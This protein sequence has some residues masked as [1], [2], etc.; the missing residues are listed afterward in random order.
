MM[1]RLGLES[2]RRKLTQDS[3]QIVTNLK[4]MKR[5]PAT[6]ED[7][8]RRA[9]SAGRREA[10]PLQ[11]QPLT[12]S[13]ILQRGMQQVLS[14][15]RTHRVEVSKELKE[16]IS[17]AF[18]AMGL[19]LKDASVGQSRGNGAMGNEFQKTLRD[20]EGEFSQA[21]QALGISVKLATIQLDKLELDMNSFKSSISR[22]GDKRDS[23]FTTYSAGFSERSTSQNSKER[24][25]SAAGYRLA[26]VQKGLVQLGAEIKKMGVK[27]KTFDE[28]FAK[29]DAAAQAILSAYK[30]AS[31]DQAE[32][33][34][35]QK[36]D[37][38][39]R[40]RVSVEESESRHTRTRYAVRPVDDSAAG[41]Q[42]EK[43]CNEAETYLNTMERL[44]RVVI[45]RD[46]GSI[47][48]TK[49][50]LETHKKALTSL[51]ASSRAAGS[52]SSRYK[53]ASTNRE[54][55]SSRDQ[56]L[57]AVQRKYKQMET[58]YER[59]SDELI[60]YQDNLLGHIE[61]LKRK[62]L[63]IE[64][65]QRE[66]VSYRE[67]LQSLQEE[68]GRDPADVGLGQSR[69]QVLETVRDV[70]RGM[71]DAYQG[72]EDNCSGRLDMI[73]E[74]VRSMH[75]KLRRC[76]KSVRIGARAKD[77]ERILREN[78][79]LKEEG[80]RLEAENRRITRENAAL[81]KS[82]EEHEQMRNEIDGLRKENSGLKNGLE[83]QSA[84]AR[85]Y[86]AQMASIMNETFETRQKEIDSLLGEKLERMDT[87]KANFE[88]IMELLGTQVNEQV[89]TI[90]QLREEN[91]ALK[92]E[93]SG[94]AVE[95]FAARRPTAK[96][97]DETAR[98]EQLFAQC[99]EAQE[100]LG[101]KAELL[102]SAAAD[103]TKR[104]EEILEGYEQLKEKM[105]G[106]LQ[107]L[108]QAAEKGKQTENRARDLRTRLAQKDADMVELQQ[109]LRTSEERL[110][111]AEEKS[112]SRI[113]TLEKE[114]GTAKSQCEV[115][116]AENEELTEVNRILRDENA[117]LDGR[118]KALKEQR[119]ASTID[120]IV[121]I[122][123]G[124]RTNYAELREHC[125]AALS[126]FALQIKDQLPPEL[127]SAISRRDSAF[128][129][130]AAIVISGM[131]SLMSFVRSAH[132]SYSQTQSESVAQISLQVSSACGLVAETQ[133]KQ[134]D[135]C[136]SARQIQSKLAVLP[137]ALEDLKS[138]CAETIRAGKASCLRKVR[139]LFE[140][141]KARSI[142]PGAEQQAGEK[143]RLIKALNRQIAA[144][145]DRSEKSMEEVDLKCEEL[146]RRLA[147][148]VAAL[149]EAQ[150]GLA[151]EF[152]GKQAELELVR[153]DY[154]PKL[155]KEREKCA[156]LEMENGS[157]NLRVKELTQRIEAYNTQITT[158]SDELKAKVVALEDSNQR[159]LEE[160]CTLSEA[161]TQ[162]AAKLADL[163]SALGEE[164]DKSTRDAKVLEDHES[165]LR[166]EL[167][168]AIASKQALQGE[169]RCAVEKIQQLDTRLGELTAN[170]KAL[171]AAKQREDDL[172]AKLAEVVAEN[173]NLRAN[174]SA[175]E[176]AR[177]ELAATLVQAKKQHTEF[178]E[179]TLR[180]K[181]GLEV[182]AAEKSALD[183]KCSE[184]REENKRQSAKMQELAADRETREKNEEGL[185][186]LLAAAEIAGPQMGD[187]YE[188]KIADLSNENADLKKQLDEREAAMKESEELYSAQLAEE[189]KKSDDL[190]QQVLATETKCERLEDEGKRR[191]AD[192]G[193]LNLQLSQ[194]SQPAKDTSTADMKLQDA[195]DS[196][197]RLEGEAK[198]LQ[199]QLE[200]SQAKT[201]DAEEK[202]RELEEQKEALGKRVVAGEEQMKE[203]EQEN[204]ELRLQCQTAI[205]AQN[206]LAQ[207]RAV[208]GPA[209]DELLGDFAQVT[210][211]KFDELAGTIARV[212][213]K[214]KL[215]CDLRSG[216]REPTEEARQILS[217]AVGSSTEG[218]AQLAQKAVNMLSKKARERSEVREAIRG[219]VA[220]VNWKIA[221][222]TAK[223]DARFR[224]FEETLSGTIK[225]IVASVSQRLQ[226]AAAP[227]TNLELEELRTDAARARIV[228]LGLL[229]TH[230]LSATH[231]QSLS[232]L[233]AAARGLVETQ[234]SSIRSL[235]DNCADIDRERS[236]LVK[237]LSSHKRES[238]ACFEA[239][240]KCVD[241]LTPG[242]VMATAFQRLAQLGS[243][244]EHAESKMRAAWKKSGERSGAALEKLRHTLATANNGLDLFA[245]QTAEKSK[246]AQEQQERIKKLE[247][248][249][250]SNVRVI[251]R[252][253]EELSHTIEDYGITLNE[254]QRGDLDDLVRTTLSI[255][256][257]SNKRSGGGSDHHSGKGDELMLTD[258]DFKVARKSSR[259]LL[260]LQFQF[261]RRRSGRSGR[262]S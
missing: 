174:L 144:A 73:A 61:R 25:E 188:K 198:K 124:I 36:D 54:V 41:S 38:I 15:L 58:Q 257:M 245:T 248:L 237:A 53:S 153:A 148:T 97:G 176:K 78:T 29:K 50:E 252:A 111:Q 162:L 88:S 105:R 40:L 154:E 145:G 137:E 164:K 258:E 114:I 141:A 9:Q 48:R 250:E 190:F 56:E 158:D 2:I 255:M 167:E 166:N 211:D 94:S 228:L 139:D 136:H 243:R 196:R 66:L 43:V 185:K 125:E 209:L 180:L 14:A 143:D 191:E 205:R 150:K 109:K 126:E 81:K 172:K 261:R 232:E 106:T 35:A 117:E 22:K 212:Q 206:E 242:N 247:E 130:R 18:D 37:E 104:A 195:L 108:T 170:S 118:C 259:L 256:E 122:A 103:R 163:T 262:R 47:E 193:R 115:K 121:R 24:P 152:E 135:L 131:K 240:R 49:Q 207:E 234:D 183:S 233:S 123:S 100:T 83:A 187:G 210:D 59:Q 85:D 69:V 238:R 213:E 223:A 182:T 45:K 184:L 75:E 119:G 244:V 220:G 74:S 236:A 142:V 138:S 3:N 23:R 76:A 19:S 224:K 7:I 11:G 16:T 42:L 161:K 200:L 82:I 113:A 127:R 227:K 95:E 89:E 203:I 31:V 249:A 26:N 253:C 80:K 39:R 217:K 79:A 102:A 149:E 129:S 226:A 72:L 254:V 21:R 44:R 93:P 116:E 246:E 1:F 10:S 52:C 57:L 171:D 189:R 215:L 99:M 107:L 120:R 157:L 194:A 179:E 62:D 155:E 230:K 70:A 132:E 219:A 199:Q 112:T 71:C 201:K 231:D 260:L 134:A 208:V 156:G 20:I 175:A 87:V 173:S 225:R 13:Y 218:L 77:T 46:E 92:R 147:A 67:Q 90:E 151:R 239:V 68:L 33:L 64:S 186:R 6:R 12:L 159:L 34:L 86:I 181:S 28:L 177:D 216:K 84:N 60:K 65:L 160:N 146:D 192:L 98:W 5:R 91:E 202:S 4:D 128:A 51:I 133:G 101:T 178:A 251:D 235:E 17:K 27:V 204:S 168:A 165:K 96:S 63:E 55:D 169:N 30:E 32:Q 214:L 222:V 110:A 221:D 241:N 140:R 8:S 197:S 229:Q